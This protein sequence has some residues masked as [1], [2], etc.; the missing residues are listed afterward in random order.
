MYKLKV[1]KIGN[2]VG[3]V[4]P[5]EALAKLNIEAG[6]TLYLTETANG[7]ELSSSDRAFEEEMQIARQVM[8]QYHDALKELAVK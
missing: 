5:K 8:T 1:S 6:E 3:I 2:S 7:F 4:L